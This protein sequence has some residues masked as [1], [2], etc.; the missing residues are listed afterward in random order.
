METVHAWED[1]VN[2]PTYPEQA[3]D[4][5]PMF[6]EKRVYQGSSG[7]VYPNPFTDRV[8]NEKIDKTYE[9]VFLENEYIRLMILPE[10]GGR[11]HVGQ[12]KTNGY[13]FF[14]RQNVIKPAL[15]GLLGP[16]ISGGVEFN[17]PQ[18]HR[19]ST[20]MPVQHAIEQHNDGSVTV[21]L[22]EHDPMQRMKG[23]VGICLH[24]GKSYIEAKVRLYN[25]TPFVQTFLW[26]ANV[27]VHV[28]EQYQAFFPPDV[29]YVADHAKR[30]ISSFPVARDF[31]YGVDYRKGV[32][33][34]WYKNIPVPTSYMVTESKYDFF[35]GYDHK[36]KAGLVHVANHHIAPGK[37]LWTWGNA[38]FGYAW[39]RNL[40]D[41]DGP[42]VELMAGVYTDNQPDFSWLQPY[43]TRTWSQ[44]WYPIQ[45][46]GPAKNANRYAAVSVEREGKQGMKVG[47]C[48]T[49]PFPG[50]KVAIS[51][52]GNT[53]R[54]QLVDLAPGKG[55][56]Q[57]FSVES[58]STVRVIANDGREIIRHAPEK[59]HSPA[60]LPAPA[61]EPPDP[62]DISSNDE[63]YITGVHLEQYRHATRYPEPYWE[64]ALRRDP[65]DSRCN[66]E[67]GLLKL[68]RGELR[69]AEQYFRRAIQ[70]LTRRNPNPA[71]S[72]AHYYLGVTLHYQ[73]RFEEAYSAYYKA[74]WNC[75]CQSAGY[76]RLAQI[77]CCRGQ[78]NTALGH[79]ERSLATNAGHL[80]SRN[81]KTAALRS[82]GRCQ[83]AEAYVSETI[84]MDP[85][86]F[87]SRN[88]LLL[89]S[90]VG[91]QKSTDEQI[92]LSLKG[93]VQL[94]LDVAF[95][96]VE[97]GFWNE[98]A[99]ILSRVVAN[100]EAVHP[101]VLYA[102]GDFAQRAGDTAA[103][104]YRA[105]AAKASPDYC[106]PSR[107]EE[108]N[109]LKAALEANPADAKARYYLGNLFYDKKRYEEAISEWEESVDLDGSFSIPWRNLGM[110]YFNVRKDAQRA[111]TAYEKAFALNPGDARLLYELDQLRKR[112]GVAAAQR[113]A[114]LEQHPDLVA[115]RDDLTV[116]VIT[117]LNQTS[118]PQK[119]LTLLSSRRF[120]PWEGGEGLVSGQYVWTHLLLGRSRLESGQAEEALKHFAAAR[121]YPHNLGEGKHLLT[122]ETHLDYFAGVALSQLGCEEEAR[123]YW[124]KAVEGEAP[125]TWM[126]YYQVLSYRALGRRTDAKR[127]LDSMRNF[128]E[129]QMQAEVKIDYFATSLP[130]FLLFEDDLQKR[131]QIDCLF[132]LALA[133]LGE[134]KAERATALFKQ[135][136]AMDG[137]HL[138]AHEELRCLGEIFGEPAEALHPH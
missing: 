77:D 113:L 24:P 83:E 53:V 33:I 29:T 25:R 54:E 126:T 49:E 98:A 122:P 35:G 62:K 138:A 109:V 51:V 134:E 100:Q 21:W 41:S 18:H 103:V 57:T 31:Y 28:H 63:L 61:S 104:Q 85:L 5:N 119:A 43:E 121:D 84:S 22:N 125:I 86:D 16:W 101:M 107:I 112:M 110:A 30:A 118:Q 17:W 9:A 137:N 123:E 76:Y 66:T 70:R 94:Q 133:E 135:I 88:E 105:A 36:R 117:L 92:L 128:A 95:D 74:V 50:A 78:F 45:E 14:Y 116:E 96:Y 67:L 81:L 23:M 131:N 90:K 114:T 37:K 2:I 47:V 39:D 79:L 26:W 89:L 87:W 6:L 32:D 68:R 108:M 91:Y 48:V 58:G 115:H 12:D 130:N 56:V 44:F 8:S 124:S 60:S 40:T 93:N 55:F 20:Y 3:P 80:N 132:I 65:M 136:L 59:L 15:V 13:D 4:K 10:I 42:Y 73:G 75:A 69:E 72:D 11:I 82:L 120:N 129:R 127:T 46:I 64:E 52:N 97:A 38:E 111:L 34:S 27:G 102:L 71:D 1:R 19:P 7:K 106:F 99:G